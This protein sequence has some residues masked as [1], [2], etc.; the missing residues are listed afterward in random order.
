MLQ[1]L[2][3]TI[4]AQE[5]SSDPVGGADE[6]E[7]E[8]TELLLPP[9]TSAIPSIMDIPPLNKYYTSWDTM[10]YVRRYSEV[11]P[12]IG[13]SISL[14]LFNEYSTGFAMPVEGDFLSPFGY[15][16][17]AGYIQVLI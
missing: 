2:I 8:E 14:P 16:V 9:S 12:S 6:N 10:Y 3:W 7:L 11:P 17:L 5:L 13:D 4:Q 1:K 15:Q